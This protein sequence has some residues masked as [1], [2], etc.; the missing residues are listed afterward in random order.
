MLHPRPNEPAPAPGER[1]RVVFVLSGYGR[2]RRGAERLVAGLV[3]RLSADFS[4]QVLGGGTDAPGAVALPLIDRHARWT[5][6]LNRMPGVGPILRVMQ[7]DPLNW[8]W[9]S[10]ARAA[11]DWL[12]N[13]PCDLLVPEGGRWGGRLGRAWRRRTGRRV[14]DIAHGAPSRW[15]IAAAQAQPDAYVASTQVSA[16]A[17]AAAVPGLRVRVIPPGVDLHAYTPAGPRAA[18][19]LQP[20]VFLSV[21]AL[22]PLKR[23]DRIVAAV[24]EF[25]RGSVWLV[26]DGPL[27]EALAAQG[28]RELGPGRFRCGPATPEEMPAVYRAADAF[29]SASR[30]EAFG[31]AQLEA[32]ASG[33]PVIAQDDAIRRE[34]LGEAGIYLDADRPAAWRPALE[35]ALADRGA[36]SRARA[37]QFSA[38]ATAARYRDLFQELLR[39]P[40]PEPGR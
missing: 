8:E 19:G 13:H 12:R 23:M 28:E 9:W 30:S 31:L 29:L 3:V 10:C 20:P 1:P 40:A 16:E 35:A 38:E 14:V 17:M 22:E 26:G 11:R 4:I 6:T 24:R 27:R 34:V 33:L 36:R 7:F 25:G 32:L 21:G 2:Y 5:R 37:E 39:R 18:P 15:E